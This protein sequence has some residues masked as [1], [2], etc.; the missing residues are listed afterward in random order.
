MQMGHD[1]GADPGD[2]AS[3][4]TKAVTKPCADQIPVRARMRVSTTARRRTCS[5]P[6]SGLDVLSAEG[7]AIAT[8]SGTAANRPLA[9]KSVR[10]WIDN[11]D[12]LARGRQ[13]P[14]AR[15]NRAVVARSKR[16]RAALTPT[17][18]LTSPRG[19]GRNAAMLTK[20]RD[21]TG[22]CHPVAQN[23]EH[24]RREISPFCSL[25]SL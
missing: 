12:A 3:L 8:G 5:S 2:E 23:N 6:D 1:V 9:G 24:Q 18:A 25:T 13:R 15:R 4:R 22:N 17:L 21:P 10:W 19:E 14:S 16:P 7:W 20:P 11:C